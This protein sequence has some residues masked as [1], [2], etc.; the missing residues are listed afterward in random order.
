MSFAIKLRLKGKK[1]W[2]FLSSRG[3]NLLRIHAVQFATADKAQALIDENRDD[4]P[5][6]EWRVV[7]FQRARIV[8]AKGSTNAIPT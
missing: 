8:P 4:N 6:W 3:T 1:R 5:E 2:A 7:D